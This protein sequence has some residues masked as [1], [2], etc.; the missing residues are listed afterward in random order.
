MKL[1]IKRSA[2]LLTA[3]VFT[4]LAGIKANAADLA[5]YSSEGSVGIIG[6]GT[7]PETPGDVNKPGEPGTPETP[8]GEKPGPGTPGPLSIDFASSWAFGKQSILSSGDI[9]AY[10]HA[11]RYGGSDYR[12]L[13]AQVTDKRGTLSGW[14][15]SL[16]QKGQFMRVEDGK[17]M[18]GAKL[19]FTG[20]GETSSTSS[21]PASVVTKSFELDADSE[22]I[23]PL[24]S[25]KTDEGAGQN[26]YS[27]GRIDQYDPNALSK[28]D[29]AKD[30]PVSLLIPANGLLAGNYKTTL[31]WSL[32][33]IPGQ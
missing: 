31:V 8:E 12:Q 28:D 3:L 18:V 10:A 7:N 30:G 14:T 19:L 25:A 27:F 33:D 1:I 4:G 29:K 13:Y 23:Q 6:G 20:P 5:S 21:K 24:L 16:S 11:Q 9:I 2:A 26:F 32:S 17:K 15:L 22:A